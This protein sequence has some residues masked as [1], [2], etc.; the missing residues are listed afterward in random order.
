MGLE[1]EG[2]DTAFQ[3]SSDE[4]ALSNSLAIRFTPPV[5]NLLR[6]AGFALDSNL[7]GYPDDW[8]INDNFR[9]WDS[10]ART[11]SLRAAQRPA[12]TTCEHFLLWLRGRGNALR[13][14]PTP[15][16]PPW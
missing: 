4:P 15:S 8:S 16:Q 1:N 7:D 14:T 10:A 5:A 6:N 2:S 12:T 9:H 3:Y 13:R 11:W